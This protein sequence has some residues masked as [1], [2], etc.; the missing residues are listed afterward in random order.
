MEDVRTVDNADREAD[1]GWWHSSLSCET[2]LASREGIISSSPDAKGEKTEG[3]RSDVDAVLTDTLEPQFYAADE[4]PRDVSAQ[5]HDLVDLELSPPKELVDTCAPEI[6][7]ADVEKAGL[8]LSVPAEYFGLYYTLAPGDLLGKQP[9][10]LDPMLFT[11]N[12]GYR[13]TAL[14]AEA[15]RLP[16]DY[17]GLWGYIHGYDH[18]AVPIPGHYPPTTSPDPPPRLKVSG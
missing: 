13:D 18:D 4:A 12:Q 6:A 17:Q 2:D 15:S 7:T 8:R 3:A 5:G 11:L 16:H 10:H 9:L 14:G 1:E